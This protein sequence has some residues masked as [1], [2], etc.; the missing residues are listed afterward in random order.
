M[1]PSMSETP[2]VV[3]AEPAREEERWA[4]VELPPSGLTLR[5]FEAWTDSPLGPAIIIAAVFSL[6]PSPGGLVAS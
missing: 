4:P 1:L 6:R 3:S 2:V 5:L